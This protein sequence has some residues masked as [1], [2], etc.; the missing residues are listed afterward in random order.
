MQDSCVYGQSDNV[1]LTSEAMN[2]LQYPGCVVLAKVNIVEMP[3]QNIYVHISMY[4]CIW[5]LLDRD[6]L[7]GNVESSKK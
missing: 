1:S 4:I 6:G 5:I 2:I 7:L 3:T